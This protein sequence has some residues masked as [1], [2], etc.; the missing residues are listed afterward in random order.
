MVVYHLNMIFTLNMI[1]KIRSNLNITILIEFKTTFSKW[2]LNQCSKTEPENERDVVSKHVRRMLG[3]RN[4]RTVGVSTFAKIV[5]AMH[6][7]NTGGRSPG[8]KIVEAM[9]YVNTGGRSPGVKIV[10]ARDSVNTG[11]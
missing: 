2:I 3:G 5:E 11:G 4:V 9:N 10:E 8:V 6:S 1:Q 7:V